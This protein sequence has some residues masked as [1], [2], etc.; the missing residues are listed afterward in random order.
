M[1][2]ELQARR[3]RLVHR[4]SGLGMALMLMV[5]A[6]SAFLRLEAAGLGC[7]EPV[8]CYGQNARAGRGPAAAASPTVAAARLAH[9]VA[10]FAALLV[11]VTLGAVS[12]GNRPVLRAEG[13]AALALFALAVFLAVLGRWSGG[14]T[15]PAVTLGNLLAGFAMLA[16]FAWLR[17]RGGQRTRAGAWLRLALVLLFAQIALGGLTAASLSGFACT[18][19]PGCA[20]SWW[21]PRWSAFDPFVLPDAA[22]LPANA[23]ASLHMAH[24]MLAVASALALIV[25]AW[26][27]ARAGARG[28]ALAVAALTAAQIASGALAVRLGLPLAAAAAHNLLAALLVCAAVAL[29]CARGTGRVPVRADVSGS[30]PP[31]G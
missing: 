21:P 20:T 2:A 22:A 10:A 7:A 12:V 15:L 18:A 31:S 29:A 11:I 17:A 5:I 19:L 28:R 23:G 14:S 27:A 13:V 4:L 8:K 25:A 6:A 30:Y 26:R 1:Y 24:R 9:R 3:A 16:L